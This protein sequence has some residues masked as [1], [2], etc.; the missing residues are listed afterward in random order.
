MY[1]VKK[2]RKNGYKAVRIPTAKDLFQRVGARCGSGVTT[3][4]DPDKCATLPLNSRK[5]DVLASGDVIARQDY[6]NALKAQE[7]AQ[8]EAPENEPA[9]EGAE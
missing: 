5:L 7:M 4:A 8:N 2:L 3:S 9:N 1:V 6:E